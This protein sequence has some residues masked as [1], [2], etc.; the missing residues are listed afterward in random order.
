MTNVLQLPSTPRPISDGLNRLFD[1]KTRRGT[2]SLSSATA[3]LFRLFPFTLALALTA[4]GAPVSPAGESTEE[5]LSRSVG[6]YCS[7]PLVSPDGN[8]VILDDCRAPG[9]GRIA[10]LDSATGQ[11]S[12]I[13]AHRGQMLTAI[14]DALVYIEVADQTHFLVHRIPFAGGPDKVIRFDGAP[15]T[16]SASNYP[17]FV[18]SRDGATFIGWRRTRVDRRNVGE[19]LVGRFDGLRPASVTRIP[20]PRGSDVHVREFLSFTPYLDRSAHAVLLAEVDYVGGLA[21]VANGGAYF[22]DLEKPWSLRPVATWKPGGR[23]IDLDAGVALEEWFD[24]TTEKSFVTRLDT[25]RDLA[26]DLASVVEGAGTSRVGA[27]LLYARPAPAPQEGRTVAGALVARNLATGSER[28]LV[29]FAPPQTLMGN[30]FSVTESGTWV[31]FGVGSNGST[32]PKKLTRLPVSG[33]ASDEIADWRGGVHV[34]LPSRWQLR[35]N[36]S[37]EFLFGRDKVTESDKVL[38]LGTRSITQL[39]GIP[40][41]LTVGATEAVHMGIAYVTS[42]GDVMVAVTGTK[43]GQ[44]RLWWYVFEAATGA[45]RPIGVPDKEGLVVKPLANGRWL[46]VSA[47]DSSSGYDVYLVD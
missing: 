26:S 2:H 28:E 33:G 1:Q 8:T 20:D 23:C 42:A 22:L 25:E 5:A 6:A 34:L 41:D 31:T 27:E 32:G 16:I 30:R 21:G 7:K 3:P 38:D 12:Q 45:Y 14:G 11:I 17:D 15:P 36:E 43:A 37:A 9:G 24:R 39:P 46:A 18:L 10:R 35:W 40:S 4:C 29:S 47:R 19:L 44:R 13:A